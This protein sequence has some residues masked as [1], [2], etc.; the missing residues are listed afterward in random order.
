MGHEWVQSFG[1]EFDAFDKWLEI[2]PDRPVLLVD[3][4]DTL[5]SGLQNAIKAFK[6]HEERIKA[7]K[8]VMGIRNDSGDLAY[9]TIEERVALDAHGLY[10]VQ[11]FETNDL[12]EYSIEA[13]K[14]Q[15]FTHAPRAGLDAKDTLRRIVWACGTQPGTC[16][17]QPSIGGVAK[18]S[19]IEAYGEERA[20]IKIAK[21]NPI[22]TSIPG[23]NRSAWIRRKENNELVC[24]LIHGKHENCSTIRNAC[25]P[26]DELKHFSLAEADEFEA[27]PRQQLVYQ[28]ATILGNPTTHDVRDL[29]KKELE[30]LHWTHRRLENPHTIKV[31]LSPDVFALRKRLIFKNQLMDR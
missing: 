21:D 14:E 5:K 23:S 18:L 2:N 7:A 12:D 29:V 1:N 16:A 15:I 24:C 11:I 25:P 13:I 6:I 26:D 22:K 4:I 17:D 19:S 27:I 31:S 28:N 9:I 3:T 8:G 30:L 20:V 10:D